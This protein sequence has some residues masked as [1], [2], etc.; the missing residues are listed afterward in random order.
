M[1]VL[2]QYGKSQ[3]SNIT[4]LSKKSIDKCRLFYFSGSQKTY[5]RDFLLS[6]SDKS[7]CSKSPANWD[8]IIEDFPDLKRKVRND[9]DVVNVVNKDRMDPLRPLLPCKI[10]D[11][12]T[13][14]W[15]DEPP[16]TFKGLKY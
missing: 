14:N 9:N 16:R 3:K 2:S 11:P 10:L 1:T 6:R 4:Y 8:K 12:S 7:Y 15:I 13:G 5:D